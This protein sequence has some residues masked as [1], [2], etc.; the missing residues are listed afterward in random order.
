MTRHLHVKCKNI[1]SRCRNLCLLQI[2]QPFTTQLP[3]FSIEIDCATEPQTKMPRGEERRFQRQASLKRASTSEQST[4][5]AI[6]FKVSALVTQV[7][8]GTIDTI[9]PV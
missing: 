7:R 2:V 1:E 8:H 5:G 4:L 3:I 6:V 9:N